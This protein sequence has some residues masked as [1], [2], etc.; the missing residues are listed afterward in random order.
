MTWIIRP[1]LASGIMGI[2]VWLMTRFL[3]GGRITT[4]L[5]VIVGI[6][7][8]GAAAYLLKAITMEDLNAVRRRKKNA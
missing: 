6:L 8:F 2:A 1:G 5:C 4:I 3:P 7:V